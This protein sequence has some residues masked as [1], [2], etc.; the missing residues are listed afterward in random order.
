MRLK[1]TKK[2]DEKL[3]DLLEHLCVIYNQALSWRKEAYVKD[4]ISIKYKDQQQSL[5]I[6]RN[7]SIEI[8]EYPSAIQRDPLRRVDRAFQSFFRRIKRKE[9]PGYPRF[10]PR[11]QY[12]SFTVDGDN[13]KF[14][15]NGLQIVKLG[16]FK[17]KTRCKYRG[18]PKELRVKRCGKHWVVTC[19]YDIG[20]APDKKAVSSAIGID[21]GL[22][23][24]VTLSDG[25]SIPNPRWTKKME[26]KLA[27]ANQSLSRKVRGSK[28]R[29][30]AKEA[31]RRIHQKIKGKRSSYLYGVSERLLKK[32]DLI[33]YEDL[34]IKNMVRSNLAKSIN[35]A[36]WGELIHQLKYKAESAGKYLIA[37]N[38]KNT[39]QLCSQCGKKVPKDLKDRVHACQC[40]LVLDRDHNAAINI[41]RL[42]ESLVETQ[43][44]CFG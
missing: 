44:G 23:S 43:K 9:T 1:V 28:N 2:Q 6:W 4:K 15:D 42:G 12:D 35:D 11:S 13:F 19:V 29:I 7:I 17:Y 31:L 38:P 22:T 18:V 10:K 41:L 36:S 30:K 3:S 8:G 16:T 21:L 34:Q 40:G 33:A 37:V 24:L 26:K 32:Y 25:S 27:E 20:P 39:T 14:T 5:A